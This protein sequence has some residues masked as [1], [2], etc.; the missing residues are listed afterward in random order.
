MTVYI[1]TSGYDYPEWKGIF[2]PQN[3]KRKDYLT[4]YSTVFNAL[5]INS[6]FY[7]MPGKDQMR[8]FYERSE[9]RLTFSI[10]ANRSLTHEISNDWQEQAKLFQQAIEVLGD[11]NV[12]GPVLLQ[13]PPTFDYTVANRKYLANLLQEFKNFKPVVE[14]RNIRWVK[15]SVFEGLSNI[16]ASLVFVDM[17]EPIKKP[18][19]TVILPFIGNNAYVRLHKKNNNAWYAED[20]SNV[21]KPTELLSFKQIIKSTIINRN[22]WILFNNSNKGTDALAATSLIRNYKNKNFANNC[23]DIIPIQNI[24]IQDRKL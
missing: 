18:D 9:G 16:G 11:N 15:E 7:N 21:W 12:L 22:M 2:Y 5:E 20:C 10:K 14:F 19:G 24:L 4:Y 8:S 6:T 17:P 3:L 23:C 13:L 1:G